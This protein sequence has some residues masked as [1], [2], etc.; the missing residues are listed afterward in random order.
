MVSAKEEEE[1]NDG[2]EEKKIKIKLET[3][4][5]EITSEGDKWWSKVQQKKLQ[6]ELVWNDLW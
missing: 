4:P 2:S 6:G 5:L 1:E 3:P